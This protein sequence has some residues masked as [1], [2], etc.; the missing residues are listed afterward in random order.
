MID[1]F[2][3]ARAFIENPSESASIDY[4]QT[5]P[6]AFKPSKAQERKPEQ[7]ELCLYY[8][9]EISEDGSILTLDGETF[10]VPEWYNKEQIKA[11]DKKTIYMVFIHYG[12]DYTRF[13]NQLI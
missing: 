7:K 4:T 9:L 12:Y 5:T 13:A 10:K 1:F 8:G 11:R 3:D 6:E 2:A